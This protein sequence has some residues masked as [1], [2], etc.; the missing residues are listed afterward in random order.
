MDKETLEDV[1]NEVSANAA[2]ISKNENFSSVILTIMIIGIIVNLVRVAQECD[3]DKTKN[4]SESS[5]NEYYANTI[6]SLCDRRSWL[7]KMRIKK[8]IREKIG[9]KEYKEYGGVLVESI[10]DSGSEIQKE[11]LI[12][13]L[14]EVN[15]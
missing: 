14:E 9:Y 1:A 2:K 12:K 11:K 3:K 6:V 4:L 13:L 5:K 8:I 7:T 10:L 15:V